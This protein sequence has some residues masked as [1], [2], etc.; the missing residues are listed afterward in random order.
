[1]PGWVPHGDARPEH[2]TANVL[3]GITDMTEALQ[4][5]W[6]KYGS[7]PLRRVTYLIT[8]TLII[9][10]QRNR[11]CGF[12]GDALPSRYPETQQPGGPAEWD[13]C[14]ILWGGSAGANVAMIA[15]SPEA[16]GVEPAN[17]FADTI[18]GVRLHN[19][20]LDGNNAAG[21]GFYGARVQQVDFVSLNITRTVTSGWSLNGTYSGRTMNCKLYRNLGRGGEEGYADTR[22]GWTS[23]DKVN[24]LIHFNLHAEANGGNEEFRESDPVLRTMS[25]GYYWGP[26]RAGLISGITAE[27]N[28]GANLV[29][30][31]SG[32]GN[33]VHG[34]YT[35]KGCSL[36]GISGADAVANGHGTRRI[37]VM[38]V[39]TAAAI[40]CGI[41]GGGILVKDSI[42]LTGTEPTSTRRESG[43]EISNLV[44][45]ASCAVYAGWANYRIINC[46]SEFVP[47]GSQPLAAFTARGGIQFEPGGDALA[48]YDEGTFTPSIAGATVAGTHTYS[49]RSGRYTRIGNRVF[50]DVYIVLSATDGMAS[51]AVRVTGLPFIANATGN[52]FSA[53]TI[54]YWLG[55]TSEISG[56]DIQYGTDYISIYRATSGSA[57]TLNGT[58]ITATT[59][60]RITGS[61]QL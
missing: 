5:V 29:I 8:D 17:G 40:N 2:H 57:S 47:V 51:G 52:T 23:Q 21:F 58:E 37:G 48:H 4:W 11:N 44:G 54:P 32:G 35:E 60:L 16:I 34:L 49:V 14:R 19:L 43:F 24:A 20:T 38:F 45:N 9:D 27:N 10:P 28:Y 61:Y 42:V 1:M 7:G 53:V 26:H 15:A 59:R 22:W 12:W 31:P 56:G 30:S 33:W 18:W 3:P 50:F 39:G 6:D 25:C 55:L 36:L 41:N 13:E 46:A